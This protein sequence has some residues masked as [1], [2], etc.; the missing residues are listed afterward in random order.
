MLSAA[1]KPEEAQ[2]DRREWLL[3]FVS[4]ANGHLINLIR[5]Q[6]ANMAIK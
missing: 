1:Q 4:E 2:R 5:G 3:A 6:R